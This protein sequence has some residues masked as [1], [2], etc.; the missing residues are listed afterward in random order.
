MSLVEEIV[1]AFS[2]EQINVDDLSQDDPTARLG[3]A[4]GDLFTGG[5][6][7]LRSIIPNDRIR[8]L[9]RVVWDLVGNKRVLTAIGPDVPSLAFTC[10]RLRGVVQ[11]I[12]LMPKTWPKMVEVDPLMQLGAICFVGVQIVDFYN[13][14]LFGDQGA[15]VRWQAYEAELLRTLAETLP[16]WA[17]NEYQQQLLAKY[18]RGIDT[19]GV[20]V[21]AYRPYQPPQEIA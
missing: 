21:Y 6:E 5:V 12:V 3:K 9:G 7:T 2:A 16:Q 4:C 11:G 14:R 15:R 18:P 1:A 19:P 13:D 20:D 8:A 17:P 10:M